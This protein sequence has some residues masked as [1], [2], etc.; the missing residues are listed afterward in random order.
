VKLFVGSLIKVVEPVDQHIL[1]QAVGIGVELGVGGEG[2]TSDFVVDEFGR[3][4]EGDEEFVLVID[5][6]VE[7]DLLV[8]DI[9]FVPVF[10]PVP[11]QMEAF[12]V[13]DQDDVGEEVDER[14]RGVDCDDGVVEEVGTFLEFDEPEVGMNFEFLVVEFGEDSFGVVVLIFDVELIQFVVDGDGSDV[15]ADVGV[16]EEVELLAFAL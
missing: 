13:V 9:S 5:V 16:V 14:F 1:V 10:D 8:I 6:H 11:D 12:T 2:C 7:I 15:H 4:V 3:G